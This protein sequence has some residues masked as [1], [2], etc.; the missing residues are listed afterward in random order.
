[1]DW[2]LPVLENYKGPNPAEEIAD[3][4]RK[5]IELSDDQVAELAKIKIISKGKGLSLKK[6]HLQYLEARLA[7][8]GGFDE[9]SQALLLNIRGKVDLYNQEVDEARFYFKLTYDAGISSQNHKSAIENLE[10]MYRHIAKLDRDIVERINMLEPLPNNRV[11]RSSG[12][13][14]NPTK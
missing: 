13:K 9:K 11:V 3:L 10:E 6:Y 12:T 2:V 1:L 5:N 4:V 14:R 8:L 7:D